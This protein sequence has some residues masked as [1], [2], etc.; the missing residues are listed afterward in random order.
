MTHCESPSKHWIC[1]RANNGSKRLSWEEYYR[2]HVV[3]EF[4]GW[5]SR[6]DVDVCLIC[7]V[8]E[9]QLGNEVNVNEAS[10]DCR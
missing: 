9:S 2:P 8:V 7:H 4:L 6:L 3:G 10:R 1:I 5:E